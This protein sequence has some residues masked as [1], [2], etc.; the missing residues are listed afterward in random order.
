MIETEYDENTENISE[1]ST[2]PNSTAENSEELKTEEKRFESGEGDEK[3]SCSLKL[4]AIKVG[5]FDVLL[6]VSDVVN[7]GRACARHF[8]NCQIFWAGLTAAFMI[9]PAYAE[10]FGYIGNWASWMKKDW[11]F[12]LPISLICFVLFNALFSPIFFDYFNISAT[13]GLSFLTGLGVAIVTTFVLSLINTLKGFAALM[14]E[15]PN[16]DG[17]VSNLKILEITM[18]RM[19]IRHHHHQL[20]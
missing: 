9:L 12:R 5:L 18:A 13:I 6:Y 1:P 15:K 19:T 20:I 14:R 2:S 4:H 8:L 17:T 7:D 3:T 10:S 11:K 16:K